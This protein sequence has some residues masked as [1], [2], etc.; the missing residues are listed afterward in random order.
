[1]FIK[2]TGEDQTQLA[3]STA[4][5][6]GA[7][8]LLNILDTFE[9]SF[10]LKHK[11]LYALSPIQIKKCKELESEII[12]IEKQIQ[13]V[14]NRLPELQAAYKPD[15]PVHT[16]D[17]ESVEQRRKRIQNLKQIQSQTYKEFYSLVEENRK[18]MEEHRVL[19]RSKRNTY[20]THIEDKLK[21]RFKDKFQKPILMKAREQAPELP[22]MN[23]HGI[24]NTKSRRH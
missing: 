9:Q 1:M 14:K 6:K 3:V 4:M 13:S 5:A 19:I 8:Q 18:N 15:N 20:D 22:E 10:P 23:G 21:E 16:P 24:R 11:E 17:S 7:E 12:D 2:I